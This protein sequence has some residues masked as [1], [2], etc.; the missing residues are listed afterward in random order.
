MA[1]VMIKCPRT[2]EPVSTQIG[3]DFDS[4]RSATMRDNV[5]GSCP[6]CGEDHVWQKEDAFPD[7]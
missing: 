5:L 3:M 2:G 1:D 7:S 4:F 6:A